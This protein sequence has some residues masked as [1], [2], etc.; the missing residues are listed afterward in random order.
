MMI[1]II[2][3]TRCIKLKQQLLPWASCQQ[4]LIN[5]KEISNHNDHYHD[6]NEDYD[7]DDGDDDHHN[8]DD[9]DNKMYK[10]KAA[11]LALGKLPTMVDQY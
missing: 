2:M 3:I 11:A 6:D 8:N 9:D 10:A 5:I 7:D 4:W 1:I